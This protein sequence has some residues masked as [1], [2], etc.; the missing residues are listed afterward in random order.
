[1]HAIV[2]DI[3]QWAQQYALVH[4]DSWVE[5]I[6]LAC[7]LVAAIVSLSLSIS[8]FAGGRVVTGLLFL[9][10]IPVVYMLGAVIAIVGVIFVI[11]WFIV[12]FVLLLTADP[13][14]LFLEGSCVVFRAH[15]PQAPVVCGADEP[16]VG[17]L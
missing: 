10:L 5:V 13:G 11:G 15:H 16:V 8:A 12:S 9:V 6:E 7:G 1:M 2:N 4:A 17:R 3:F 14:D